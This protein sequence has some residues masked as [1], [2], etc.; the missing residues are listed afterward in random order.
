MCDVVVG[1]VVVVVGVGVVVVAC[2][3]LLYLISVAC[4]AAPGAQA[5][6]RGTPG[7]VSWPVGRLLGAPWANFSCF[8][9]FLN[10]SK[11]HVFLHHSKMSKIEGQS[12]FRMH[13]G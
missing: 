10:A 13:F 3:I 12:D 4:Q 9:P 11:S 8:W 2:F 5:A 1:V 6:M 7:R